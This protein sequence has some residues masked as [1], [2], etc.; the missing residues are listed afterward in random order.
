MTCPPSSAPSWRGASH[1]R[2]FCVAQFVRPRDHSRGRPSLPSTLVHPARPASPIPTTPGASPSCSRLP[3]RPACAR[4]I[5]RNQC[6]DP[7]GRLLLFIASSRR[8]AHPGRS[9]FLSR[10]LDHVAFLRVGARRWLLAEHCPSSTRNPDTRVIALPPRRSAYERTAAP[11]RFASSDPPAG[12]IRALNRRGPLPSSGCCDARRGRGRRQLRA[13]ITCIAHHGLDLPIFPRDSEKGATIEPDSR[14]LIGVT[15]Y[16]PSNTPF[17][18][19]LL[20]SCSPYLLHITMRYL[21]RPLRDQPPS[22]PRQRP[23]IRVFSA[24]DVRVYLL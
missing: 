4:A 21:R 6:S 1:T 12:N 8:P 17:H 2:R 5:A 16:R 15:V 20:T 24:R 23:A 9:L 13:A 22:R 19:A 14:Q 7:S 10:T 18:R 11:P 3:S